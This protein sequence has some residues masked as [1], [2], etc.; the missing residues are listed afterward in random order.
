[1]GTA[2]KT[3][4]EFLDFYHE[5]VERWLDAQAD[6]LKAALAI[7]QAR[8]DAQ[9][10][11]WRAQDAAREHERHTA[12]QR[13]TFSGK[14]AEKFFESRTAIDNEREAYHKPIRELD[15]QIERIKDGRRDRYDKYGLR[16]RG[17][18]SQLS[19]MVHEGWE[20]VACHGSDN[21]SIGASGGG[22]SHNILILL[23]RNVVE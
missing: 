12:E 20:I 11:R 16:R 19:E 7:Q 6:A 23:R 13:M 10:E 18:L 9:K 4:F 17:L 22:S 5:R 21:V 15:E 1:M 14:V 3:E 2:V 8:L